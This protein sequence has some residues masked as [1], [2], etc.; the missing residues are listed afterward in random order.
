MSRATIKEMAAQVFVAYQGNAIAPIRAL[1]DNPQVEDAYAV[2]RENHLR[3]TE[4][5]RRTI[6]RKIG[7]T[8]AAIQTQLGVDQ[9]DYGMVYEIGRAHV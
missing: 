8:S 4:A 5:G 1:V 2:Q 3:W 7:L 9:P 6:G